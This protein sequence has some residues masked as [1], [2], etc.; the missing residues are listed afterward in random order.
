VRVAT[1]AHAQVQAL[2][3]YSEI[4][5]EFPGIITRRSVDH[6]AFVRSAVGGPSQPLFTLARVD[7]V[8]LVTDV[9]ETDTAAVAVGQP[10]VIR[11]DALRG[12][13]IPGKVMRLADALDPSTRTMRVEVEP[14]TLPNGFR[15]GQFGTVAITLADH[16]GA[17]MLPARVLLTGEKP[18]VLVVVD[19]R[20]IRREIAVGANDGER[21]QIVAGLSGDETIVADGKDAVRDGQ[22]VEVVK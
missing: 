22:A 13:A 5:A 8:R 6:G 20:A 9:P 17:V 15:A 2:Y 11:I 3:G 14:E 21:V 18:A 19:G 1:A 4:R 7:R 12:P 16:P 10:A